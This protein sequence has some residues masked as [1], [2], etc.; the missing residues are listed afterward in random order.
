MSLPRQVQDQIK[1]AE[2]LAKDLGTE[3]QTAASAAPAEPIQDTQPVQ[4]ES[5]APEVKPEPPK[6]EDKQQQPD[7]VGIW[8]QRY[9]VLQGKYNSE[10]RAYGEQVR[11][12][13]AR[14]DEALGYVQELEQHIQA[15]E[16]QAPAQPVGVTEQQKQD[17]GEDL[18]AFIT[19]QADAIASQKLGS[20]VEQFNSLKEE[21]EQLRAQLQ[22]VGQTANQASNQGFYAELDA[23]APGWR[24]INRDPSL[25][26]WL[27]Q[28]VPGTPY[29]RQDFLNDAVKKKN[30]DAVVEMLDAYQADMTP[31]DPT[32]PP[33]RQ[34]VDTSSLESQIA[35]GRR[36]GAG[37]P[38][39][40]PSEQ[41]I[42]RAE[43]K[44]F[45][46]D[47]ALGR[48]R[49]RPQEKLAMEQRIISAGRQDRVT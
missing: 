48:Y 36:T 39:D 9:R 16:I 4:P 24:E 14:L 47:V 26:S 23:R 30:V 17:Y 31:S 20:V 11:D 13:S 1:R 18:I 40:G 21:N 33:T 27:A 25:L 15:Q 38:V 6:P 32:P 34:S 35:P 8:E 10:I 49:N 7:T 42:S 12:L 28:R 19:S 46:D 29:T 41:P 3:E 22:S 37:T 44:K 5:A 45:Y 2:K 43:I